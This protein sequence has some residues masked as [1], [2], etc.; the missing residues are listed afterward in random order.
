MD[1]IA[2]IDEEQYAEDDKLLHSLMLN[3]TDKFVRV[4]R[5]GRLWTMDELPEGYKRLPKTWSALRLDRIIDESNCR[6]AIN[7]RGG[8]RSLACEIAEGVNNFEKESV[9]DFEEARYTVVLK[10]PKQNMLVMKRSNKY[11]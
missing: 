9:F 7:R 2:R 5:S 6:D 8:L 11:T 3:Y 1:E 10:C 4:S